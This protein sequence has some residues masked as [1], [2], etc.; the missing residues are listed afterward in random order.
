MTLPACAPRV[1]EAPEPQVIVRE[2]RETPPS[3][4][5]RC[6]TPPVGLPA[7][8][9]ATLPAPVRAGVIRL[10]KYAGELAAQLNRNIAWS[11]GEACPGLPGVEDQGQ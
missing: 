2:V 11:T 4:L 9:V 5:T 8:Q 1:A 6:P 3:E 10:A 7:D